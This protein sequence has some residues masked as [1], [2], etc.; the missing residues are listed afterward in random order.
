MVFV[1]CHQFFVPCYIVFVVVMLL[2]VRVLHLLSVLMSSHCSVCDAAALHCIAGIT[3]VKD[4]GYVIVSVD[5]SA[6]PAADLTPELR[7]S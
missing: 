1:W 6:V 3:D 4:V 5:D 7:L 2:I